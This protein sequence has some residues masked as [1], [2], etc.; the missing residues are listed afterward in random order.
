MMGFGLK[1]NID[2]KYISAG[3]P[4]WQDSFLISVIIGQLCKGVI[5]TVQNSSPYS[6]QYAQ[7]SVYIIVC[8]V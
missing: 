3:P 7:C 2:R 5:Y 6:A 1:V 4:R 8:T